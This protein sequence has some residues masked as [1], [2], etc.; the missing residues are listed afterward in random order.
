MSSSKKMRNGE[1][2]FHGIENAYDLMERL[3]LLWSYAVGHVGGGVDGLPDGW[4]RYV[5]PTEDTNRSRWP[6]HPDWQVIQ[7]AFQPVEAQ[8]EDEEQE[9]L[10]QEVDAELAARPMVTSFTRKKAARPAASAADSVVPE[11]QVPAAA[12][13]IP[14]HLRPI[15]RKRHYEVNMCASRSSVAPASQVPAAAPPIPLHLR[16]I[17][18]KRHYEVNM[19]RMVAQVAGCIVTTEAWR[20]YAD[21]AVPDDDEEA[22][23]SV[24]LHFLYE[25]IQDYLEEKQRDFM[26]S[27]HHKR[28]VYQL[29]Q[30]AAA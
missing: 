25:H 16:P 7:T 8:E 12:L 9:A 30:A 24:T 26:K 13:P 2:V 18:R 1:V 17:V 14:L 23:L 28:V 4:L 15:V 21:G 29:E 5:V 3:P 27:V 20:P 6:V 19:R 22:D 10:L 11:S